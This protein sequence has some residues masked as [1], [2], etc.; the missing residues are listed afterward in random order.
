MKKPT[1][2]Q[3]T[4]IKNLNNK[5]RKSSK[6]RY[7]S[8]SRLKRNIETIKFS[9]K[10][11]LFVPKERDR[12]V[13]L[14]QAVEL[15]TP[16]K[17]FLNFSDV[18]VLNPLTALY[19]THTLDRYPDVKFHA[20]FCKAVIPRAVFKLLGINKN[21]SLGDINKSN[22]HTYVD[23]WNIFSGVDGDLPEATTE[24]FKKMKEL[25]EDKNAFFKLF[26]AIMEAINNVKQHAYHGSSYKKWFMLTHV[27]EKNDRNSKSIS[28][29][30]S[31]LGVS[32]P[33]TAP[34]TF[35]ERFSG[36]LAKH[37]SAFFE[38]VGLVAEKKIDTAE[39]LRS[40]NDTKLIKIAT[41]LHST[42]TNSEG[43]GKGFSDILDLVES[44]KK[45]KEIESVTTHVLSRYGSYVYK[46]YPDGTS[47]EVTLKDG[48]KDFDNQIKGT[49]ISWT[50]Q[51]T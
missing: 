15:G 32:V 47:K 38:E 17:Y 35:A 48:L 29:V 28:V 11:S 1:T 23:D 8:I 40:F 41:R 3:I 36:S 18:E 20:K 4:R 25:F 42:S 10:L 44:A 34:K 24:H 6:S 37:I 5:E 50:I 31:D 16:N 12:I 43:R 21:F 22:Y 27:S 45:Y 46:A 19:I 2:K 13:T 9:E 30:V 33:Y 49:V 14:A 39:E 26:N 51:F 7:N